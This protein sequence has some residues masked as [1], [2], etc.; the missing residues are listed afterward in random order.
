MAICVNTLTCFCILL[1][2]QWILG[3]I[4]PVIILMMALIYALQHII[5]TARKRNAISNWQGVYHNVP[6]GG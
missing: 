1:F 2:L 4:A 5:K 6:S 3:I